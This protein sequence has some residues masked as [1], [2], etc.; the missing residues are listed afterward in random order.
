MRGSKHLKFEASGSLI[1]CKDTLFSKKSST[2]PP[3]AR[4]QLPAALLQ[5]IQGV[6]ITSRPFCLTVIHQRR[7]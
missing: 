3:S 4:A 5:P 6:G 7:T 2:P 1:A